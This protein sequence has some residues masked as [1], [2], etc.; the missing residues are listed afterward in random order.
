MSE[1]KKKSKKI[2]LARKSKKMTKSRNRDWCFTL[3]NPDSEVEFTSKM[4]YLVYQLE[5]GDS[6][7][8][9]FQGFVQFKRECSLANAKKRIGQNAHLEIRSKGTPQQAADYCKK[10]PRLK[11]PVEYGILSKGQGTRMDVIKFRDAI[12]AGKRKRELIEEMPNAYSRFV[13]FYREV[14]LL[15][16]P[17][18]IKRQTLLF[19]GDTGAGKTLRARN[20]PEFK[21]DGFWSLPISNDKIWFD[22]YDEDKNVLLDDFAGKMSK[23]PL[24]SLLQLLHEYPEKVPIKGSFVWWNPKRIIITTNIHPND[25]YDYSK[26]KEQYKALARRINHV[27][28]FT[29]GEVIQDPKDFWEYKPQ[30]IEYEHI[31]HHNN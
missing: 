6:G 18:T 26:R 22:G 2:V 28:H 31:Y 23:M 19:Y 1:K 21:K 11:P 27:Y 4:K 12:R 5:E 7:T 16:M 29:D 10:E 15:E 14:V 17:K 8:P 24:T 3:N 20:C 25:W 9:H 30:Q 13:Q